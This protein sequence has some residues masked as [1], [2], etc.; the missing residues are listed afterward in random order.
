VVDREKP[1]VHVRVKNLGLSSGAGVAHGTVAWPRFWVCR[2]RRADSRRTQQQRP[3]MPA[4]SPLP[5]L[6]VDVQPS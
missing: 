5:P 1:V 4:G 2:R 3:A 6:G